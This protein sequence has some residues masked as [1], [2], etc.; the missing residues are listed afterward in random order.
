MQTNPRVAGCLW[1]ISDAAKAPMIYWIVGIPHNIEGNL[2]VLAAILA[3]STITR[4]NSKDGRG[5]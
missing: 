2:A 4:E 1:T 5:L 3:E